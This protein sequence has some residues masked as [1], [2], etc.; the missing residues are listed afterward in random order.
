MFI[1]CEFMNF[2]W[3][4]MNREDQIRKT[5]KKEKTHISLLSFKYVQEAGVG[6]RSWGD[7]EILK[8]PQGREEKIEQSPVHDLV[9]SV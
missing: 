8:F 2:N 9:H 5:E 1:T 4:C 3:I 7:H 6:R